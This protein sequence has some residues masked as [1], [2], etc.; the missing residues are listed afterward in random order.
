MSNR[1]SENLYRS[2]DTL[3]LKTDRLPEAS[4][5]CIE[6]VARTAAL[7][8]INVYLVGGIVRDIVARLPVVT[9]SPDV[10]VIGDA[11]KFA[12]AL[13]VENSDCSLMSASQLHTAKVMIGA[14][15]V[16]I[17]SA[18][19]DTYDPWGSLPQIKLVD[20]IEDDLQ[21]RDFT[22]NAMAV[23]LFHD[24]TGVVIDPFEGRRDVAKRVMRVI[25]DDSF[26]EDPLR[27]MRGVRLA[28][29]HGYTF[30]SETAME[31]QRSL[32]HLEKMCDVSPQRVF[33]EFRLWFQAHEDLEVLTTMA[34][35]HGILDVFVPSTDFR[36]G[37]FRQIADDAGAM[38]RFAVFAHLASVD[39]MT[40]LAERLKMP[41][42]WH[43]IVIETGIAR[44]IAD[45]CRS[46]RISDVALW[47]SLSEI[48][49]E[50]I[51]AAISVESSTVALSRLV[52]Y[53][54]R[55]R[56]M[57]TVLKGD[58]LIALGIAEGP[59]IGQILDSLLKL[60]IEGKLSSVEEERD[61]VMR[62]LSGG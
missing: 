58:D 59:M 21:R 57:G 31:I 28:A 43:S 16:D 34:C 12:R 48:R 32:H 2:S 11:A 14:V 23:Q 20:Q 61:Y 4:I 60:R 36:D 35:E 41:S 5:H 42:D 1:R 53:R 62:Y 15:S 17:A 7:H 52:N 51:G 18:R 8:G 47:R 38:E 26:A 37:A 3:S 13:V 22:V 33:N 44:G 49:D 25:R 46:E 45:R 24:D 30:E 40:D 54:T 10:T 55:L 19:A 9:T 39:A 6:T 56:N 29:R 50:V 27:M